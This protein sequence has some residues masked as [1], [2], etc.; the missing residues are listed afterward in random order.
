DFELRDPNGYLLKGLN[1]GSP[2]W[3]GLLPTSGDY[4]IVVYNDRGVR[5]QYTVEAT[6]LP[7]TAVVNRP[8]S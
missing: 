5:V 3:S 8:P 1:S 6:I 4:T 2:V 7:A